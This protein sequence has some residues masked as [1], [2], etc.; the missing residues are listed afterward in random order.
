[1]KASI[2]SLWISLVLALLGIG[3]LWILGMSAKILAFAFGLAYL[4]FPF[5]RWFEVRKI[6][7]VMTI[8]SITFFGALSLVGLTLWIVPVL[9]TEIIHLVDRMPS[10]LQEVFTRLQAMAV[11]HGIPFPHSLT[12]VLG[13][14]STNL[15]DLSSYIVNP[16]LNV[17]KSLVSNSTALILGLTNLILFPVFFFFVVLDYE[18]IISSFK[19]VFPKSTRI[20]VDH[21]LKR[22]DEILSGF[23]R[24]QFLVCT[25]LALLYGLGLSLVGIPFGF[26]IGLVGGSLSFIPYVGG[27]IVVATSIIVAIATGEPATTYIWIAIVFALVQSLESFILTPRLVGKRLGLSSL[28]SI[29]AVIAGANLMGFIGMI[30]AIPLGSLLKSAIREALRLHENH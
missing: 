24:G 23:I 8:L 15:S 6:P 14:I 11:E 27:A 2:L 3:F 5:V 17:A 10:L 16:A 28:E 25:C 21:W 9:L 7:R 13:Y 29:L 20:H 19:K 4:L 1:M 30:L 22:A 12:E 18:K 26:A